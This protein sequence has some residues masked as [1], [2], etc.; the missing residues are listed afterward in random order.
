MLN[1][2]GFTIIEMLFTLSIVII[3]S[4]LSF[5]FT[6][7][8]ASNEE[9]LDNYEQIKSLIEE[10]R[11]IALSTHQRVDLIFTE[12]NIGYEIPKKRRTVE[13]SRGISFTHIRNIYFNRNGVINQANHILYGSK[14]IQYKIVFT[15]G[16]GD[17]Y[18]Q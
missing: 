9:I 3:L 4:L 18:L 7:K 14:D 12:K 16:S 5:S 2:S 6:R 8:T 13:L 15:L 11:S 1:K 10:A 17:F